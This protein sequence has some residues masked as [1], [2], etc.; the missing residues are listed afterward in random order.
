LVRG[1]SPLGRAGGIVEEVGDLKIGR[2]NRVATARALL[3]AVGEGR[4]EPA[5]EYAQALAKSVLE[6]RSVGLARAVLDAGPFAVR[7][8]IDLA[9]VVLDSARAGAATKVKGP[10]RSGA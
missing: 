3:E 9:E 6:D 5:W 1:S 8:A 7:R 4:E 10:R 2:G